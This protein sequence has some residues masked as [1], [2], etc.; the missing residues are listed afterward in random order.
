MK[1]VISIIMAMLFIVS[2]FALPSSAKG[3]YTIVSPYEDVIW[4]GKNAWG[5]Y[6][7]N[8]HTH[9]TVSDAE[10]DYNEM[11][12]EHH[13][14]GFDFLAMTD[15]GVTGKVWNEEPTHIPLYRYQYIIGN[16]TTKITDEE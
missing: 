15:H 3:D 11:I 10:M 7:G 5:A 6:K 14:Q 4:S 8:L 12:I 9:S 13:N 1:K 16:K 2:A